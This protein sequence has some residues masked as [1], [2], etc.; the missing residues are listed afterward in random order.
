MRSTNEP[1]DRLPT[2][3]APIRPAT[4]P[5]PEPAKT[6]E[7]GNW[8]STLP[9]GL[10]EKPDPAPAPL[11]WIPTPRDDE[12]RGLADALAAIADWHGY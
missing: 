8:Q 7:L 5:T 9:D 2:L 10:A 11:A 12:W 3:G 4:P 1:V 6:F